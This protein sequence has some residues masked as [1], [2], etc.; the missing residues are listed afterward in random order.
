MPEAPA[1]APPRAWA[2]RLHALVLVDAWAFLLHR[3]PAVVDGAAE[4]LEAAA[5]RWLP[6]RLAAGVRAV[7]AQIPRVP[8]QLALL[9]GV[10]LILTAVFFFTILSSLE[11]SLS[12]AESP[13]HRY[14]LALEFGIS[15]MR[16]LPE[17][18]VRV[19]VCTF[20]AVF[21]LTASWNLLAQGVAQARVRERVN[22]HVDAHVG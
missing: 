14:Q 8:A 17:L 18:T 21:G 16:A 7:F 13:E 3:L 11:S 10:W 12:V 22:M 20:V 2:H 6:Q 9:F 19:F 1:E 4:R 5:A 15:W